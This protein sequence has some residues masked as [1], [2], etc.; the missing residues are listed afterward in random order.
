MMLTGTWEASYQPGLYDI[1]D[2]TQWN[3]SQE[4]IE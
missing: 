2:W 3:Y 4:E 1:T